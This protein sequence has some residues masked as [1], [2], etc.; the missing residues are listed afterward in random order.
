MA[1]TAASAILNRHLGTAAAPPAVRST[2]PP[3]AP[4]ADT[5]KPTFTL[6]VAFSAPVILPQ[7][8]GSVKVVPGKPFSWLTA[9]QVA[10]AF[11]CSESS[12]YRYIDAGDIPAECVDLIGVRKKRIRADAIERAR[13]TWR[14]RRAAA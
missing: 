3:L 10:G 13:A 14:A 5:L 9:K 4:G 8:D 1:D 12:V 11:G 6:P 7:G 2:V